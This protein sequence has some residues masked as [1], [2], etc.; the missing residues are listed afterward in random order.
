MIILLIDVIIETAAV[1]PG[2]Q[3]AKYRF[4]SE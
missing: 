3:Q 2:L 1:K 4:T